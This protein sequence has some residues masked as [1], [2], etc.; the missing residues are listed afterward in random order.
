MFDQEYCSKIQPQL[1]ALEQIRGDL[2]KEKL[3]V[4]CITV[5]GE[6]SAG[7]SSVMEYIADIKFPRAENT[8]T[9][10]PTVASLVCDSSIEAPYATVGLDPDR[11]THERVDDLEQ[12]AIKIEE[13]T[14]ELTAKIGDGDGVITNEPIYVRVVRPSG[15]TLTLIDLPGITHM[16][17]DGKQ[18]D[19]HEVT[20]GLI[21]Q[22][23]KDENAVVLVVIPA[24]ADFGNAEAL[25][26]AKKYDPYGTRTLG[27]VTKC[28]LSKP[29][30]NLV[31]KIRMEGKNI[32]LE[33]GFV[34]LRCRTPSEVK[35]ELGREEAMAKEKMLFT[36]SPH[37]SRL[38]D[39]QWGLS[40][41][42]SKIVSVQSERVGSFIPEFR[43][44]L[45]NKL[46]DVEMEL[47]KFPPL[48]TTDAA[49][50][51]RMES[52]LRQASSTL[53]DILNGSTHFKDK[54]MHLPS[55]WDKKSNEFEATLRK[56]TPDFFGAQFKAVL[57]QNM[58]EVQG[59]SLPNFMSTPVF[60]KALQTIYFDKSS[61]SNSTDGV[62]QIATQTI[63]SAIGEAM[64]SA[65]ESLIDEHMSE[66]PKLVS[67]FKEK[68]SDM[69]KTQSSFVTEHVKVMLKAELVKPHTHN[70]Y[71]A[72]TIAKARNQIQ[73]RSKDDF[74]TNKWEDIEDIPDSFL[75]NAAASFN[76]G[77]SNVEQSICDMQLSLYS[78]CKSMRKCFVDVVAKLVWSEMM[79]AV[80]MDL[81]QVLKQSVSDAALLERLMA[82]DRATAHKREKIKTTMERFSKSLSVLRSV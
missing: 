34:A 28:D 6:Q 31:E 3:S 20:T 69:I 58:D 57:K 64:L 63:V 72:D 70:H 79:H 45:A 36:T 53:H 47:Q 24:T 80:D 51:V 55:I 1:D 33:M 11:K 26:M 59:A 35:S 13:L 19:I 30:D 46:H 77:Q 65:I 75:H 39:T 23:I 37:L 14:D 42:V 74:N 60:R 10:C 40:T 25:K 4:P 56:A 21:D 50:T 8:C 7:K 82:E 41:L 62:L 27:V 54:K 44:L 2:N 5:V 43:L 32:Q 61:A 17:T 9:R 73:K 78:Y 49:R 67:F 71:Y 48:C 66:S 22:Y 16:C 18:E 38:D 29:D 76:S 52:M 15:P 81:T 12:I 68:L